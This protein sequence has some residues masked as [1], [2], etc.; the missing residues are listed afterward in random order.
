MIV[1]LGKIY[2]AVASERGS[3]FIYMIDMP[4]T[5]EGLCVGSR[6]GAGTWTAT[7]TQIT[8]TGTF[9]TYSP[10]QLMGIARLDFDTPTADSFDEMGSINLL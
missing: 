10:G 3:F 8:F 7:V 5:A 6:V 1:L 9:Y 4:A 2:L